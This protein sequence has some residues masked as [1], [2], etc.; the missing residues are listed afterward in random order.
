MTARF[1]KL[2]RKFSCTSL[3]LAAVGFCSVAYAAGSTASGTAAEDMTAVLSAPETMQPRWFASTD[4]KNQNADYLLLKPGETRRIPLAAGT[5]ERLWS[6]ALVPEKV[7]LRLQNGQ[8]TTLLAAGRAAHGEVYEKAL[9]LY[10]AIR[11]GSTPEFVR[12]LRSGAALVVTNGAPVENKFFYQATVRERARDFSPQRV[13]AAAPTQ[14]PARKITIAPGESGGLVQ[15]EVGARAGIVQEIRI[16]APQDFETL[17]NLRL[18]VV[19]M[20]VIRRIGSHVSSSQEGQSVLVDVPL[21]ALCSQFFADASGRMS[22][23]SNAITSFDG[24]TIVVRWPMPFDGKT[25]DMHI[26]LLNAGTKPVET[27]LSARFAP[28]GEASPYRFHALAG[29][30][31][32]QKGKPIEML[33]VKGAGAFAGLNLAIAPRADSPRQTFA[34]L[35]G[36]ETIFADD[37][38]YEGTGTEDFFNSAWYYPKQAFNRPYHGLTFKSEKPPRVACY[39]LMPQDAVPFSKSLRFVL[40]HGNG[41]NSDDLEY[42]WVAFWYAKTGS[43]ATVPD[44]LSA[45]SVSNDAENAGNSAVLSFI[46]KALGAVLLVVTLMAL[47]RVLRR[48]AKK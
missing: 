33:Q 12:K 6:T 24:K 45:D 5:L 1:T 2:T 10:P 31:R 46:P 19:R 15:P 39:R 30:A 41:N 16:A 25:D 17:S 37:K 42:Q 44:T 3:A 4:P 35:E 9:T 34:Y 36:N 8:T 27:S 22:P 7:T 32:S 21:S 28:L 13:L 47:A 18:R 20:R 23:M 48:P 43:T 26:D 29:S 40:E 38:V 11:P 14:T